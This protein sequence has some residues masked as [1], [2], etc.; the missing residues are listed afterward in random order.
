MGSK[1]T[2]R[3]YIRKLNIPKNKEL[4]IKQTLSPKIRV[5]SRMS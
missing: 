3:L 4:G 1:P 2:L 5:G